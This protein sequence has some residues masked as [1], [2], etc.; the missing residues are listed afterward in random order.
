MTN[1]PLEGGI[2]IRQ[3]YPSGRLL[4]DR[5]RPTKKADARRSLGATRGSAH[6]DKGA[7]PST[8][9]VVLEIGLRVTGLRIPRST[10]QYFD[11]PALQANV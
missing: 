10:R 4:H 8:G 5:Y 9:R 6:E 11:G 7:M 2:N 3:A 1:E